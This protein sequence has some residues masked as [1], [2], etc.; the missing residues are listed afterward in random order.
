MLNIVFFGASPGKSSV[1]SNM[2]A[3]ATF[4]SVK[5]QMEVS[6]MQAQFNENRLEDCFMPISSLVCMKEDFAYYRREGIDEIIDNIR[7][8]RGNNSFE[9]A[10]INV[11]SS[12]MFYLP[13][14][15]EISEELFERECE[16]EISKIVS[17]TSKY[18]KPNFIDC[19]DCRGGLSRAFLENADLVVFNLEQ[20][21]HCIPKKIFEE[22]TFMEKSLFLIGRYDDNSRYNIRNIRR[23]YHIDESCIATIPYNIY[24]RD[25]VCE[26]K[27]IDYFS[28]N[29]NCNR[30]NDNYNFICGVNG[31]V[32]MILGKVGIG[33][34]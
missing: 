32:D 1:S 19:R 18:N 28:R 12:R 26:G 15:S 20:G 9:N 11:K 27:I 5:Y 2:L 24:F 21:L 30:D 6:V 29:I 16:K 4:A 8:G 13:S 34:K 7:L 33:D 17:I 22:K 10:L 23:K 3:V 25:A 31:A 14:T